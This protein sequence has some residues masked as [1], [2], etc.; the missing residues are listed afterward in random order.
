M[1]SACTVFQIAIQLLDRLQT[2]NSIGYVHRDINTSNIMVGEEDCTKLY[3][4]D[5]GLAKP[6]LQVDSK[7]HIQRT[8]G[9]N[10]VGTAKFA[11]ISSHEGY[12]MEFV[13]QDQYPKDDLESLAYMLVY[14]LK[15]RLLW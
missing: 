5:F 8:G 12:G 4:I 14:F 7:V 6:Y 9:R 15:G 1:F 10:F 13:K 11:S 3:L 2:L